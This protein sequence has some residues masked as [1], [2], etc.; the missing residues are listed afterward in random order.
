MTGRSLVTLTPVP[1]CFNHFRVV[2]CAKLYF[3]MNEKMG[4]R[5]RQ[6]VQILA[7]PGSS[8]MTSPGLTSLS[9][10]KE[11]SDIHHTGL[12]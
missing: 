12:L 4:F 1:P 6:Q 10:N 5:N 11:D 8:C 3:L 9:V 7:V 2:M